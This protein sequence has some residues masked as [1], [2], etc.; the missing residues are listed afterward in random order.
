MATAR[1]EE[2]AMYDVIIIGSGPAGLTAAVYCVQKRLETLIIGD[3]WGGKTNY[4]M[5][6]PGLEGHELIHGLE[7]VERFKAQ[8][9]YLDFARETASVSKAMVAD[10]HYAVCTNEG[11]EFE[12]RTLII[13]TGAYPRTLGLREEARLAGHGL[14]Y[15]IVSH[16]PLFFGNQVAVVGSGPEAIRGA[17]ELSQVARRVTVLAP[18]RGDLDSPL[19]RMLAQQA[20]VDIVEGATVTA[21]GGK[22]SVESVDYRD[23]SGETHRLPVEGLFVELGLVPST[24]VV[25]DLVA[26]DEQRRI[27]INTA[28][29]TS[30]PGVFAAGDV[31]TGFAEQVLIAIG[32]G[33]KAALSCYEYLLRRRAAVPGE[34]ATRGAPVAPAPVAVA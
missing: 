9:E 25:A 28:N 29:E 26:L 1:H 8:I 31:T 7:I 13:A 30:R 3:S 18:D 16:A 19:G 5:R 11:I 4:R 27:I 14:S 12:S 10:D 23:R 34:A 6:V 33:A 20:H 32:E 2:N 24:G 22:T 21:I 15:S 17:G